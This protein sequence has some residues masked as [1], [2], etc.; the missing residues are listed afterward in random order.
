MVDA[1]KSR[2]VFSL[3]TNV[4][5]MLVALAAG[6]V[7]LEFG[8]RLV[9]PAYDPS[10]HVR[11]T[12][13]RA[14]GFPRGPTNTTVRQVKNTGDYDVEVSFNALGLRDD[15]D[16]GRAG[17]NDLVV[18]GD[19]F[20]FGWG[21][22]AS[23]RYSNRL[24][25]A[26]G[27]AVYN[28]AMPGDLDT[29]RRL[30]D[31]VRSRGGAVRRVIVGVCME[32]DLHAYEAGPPPGAEAGLVEAYGL[33]DIKGTL[34]R[35]SAAYFLLTTTVHRIS[36]LK[37]LAVAL[38]L[39]VPNLQGVHARVYSA[40]VIEAS[41]RALDRVV[42]DVD[43][44]ILLIPARGLWVGSNQDQEDRIHREFV[45]ALDARGHDVIDLRPVFEEGGTPLAYHFPNDGHWNVAGHAKAAQVLARH[46]SQRKAVP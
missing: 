42:E 6:L 4:G 26:L 46:L 12:Q 11:L 15:K 36:A 21:V 39:V 25:T 5:V 8:V 32:N 19:S 7:L 17:E 9:F 20:S 33:S 34:L 44:T 35:N 29:Y 23:A 10:G 43:A 31:F 16:P 1:P 22:E 24:E 41:L 3:A 13:D 14:Q 28:V 37:D 30:L 27:R 2:L 40:P 18:V 38:G 45:A